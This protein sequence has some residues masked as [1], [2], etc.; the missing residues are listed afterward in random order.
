FE[1]HPPLRLSR[2][3][4]VNLDEVL[5]LEVGLEGTGLVVE[6][7][8]PVGNLVCS[9][10]GRRRRGLSI[11]ASARCG[12]ASAGEQSSGQY[13]LS[14]LGGSWFLGAHPTVGRLFLRRMDVP[15][16]VKVAIGDA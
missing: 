10:A 7:L 1:D 9:G 2:R 4:G 8:D 5:L 12:Q 15:A 3:I 16:D 6:C 13:G 11:D 14:H